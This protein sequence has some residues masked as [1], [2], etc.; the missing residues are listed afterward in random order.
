MSVVGKKHRHGELTGMAVDAATHAPGSESV[1]LGFRTPADEQENVEITVQ[2]AVA[3][4]GWLT[5][6]VNRIQGQ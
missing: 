1:Y 6:L 4:H 3:L 5:K 2:E